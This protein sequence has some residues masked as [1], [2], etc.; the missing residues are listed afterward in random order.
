MAQTIRHAASLV[1][2]PPLYTGRR[3]D[4]ESRDVDP[5]QVRE[6]RLG[7]H[8]VSRHVASGIKHG[9]TCRWLFFL[10]ENL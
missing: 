9:S 8:D 4:C 2:D 3:P 1:T 7:H 10:H 5:S 6:R